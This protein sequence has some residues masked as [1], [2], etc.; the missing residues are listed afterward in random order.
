M[1]TTER[2]SAEVVRRDGVPRR[3]D[4]VGALWGN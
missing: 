4:E 2:E 1:D 3:G